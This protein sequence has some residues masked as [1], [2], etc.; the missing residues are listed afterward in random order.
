[1]VYNP[2]LAITVKVEINTALGWVDVTTRGRRVSC[3][4]QQGRT[5]NA[6]QAEPSRLSLTLGNPDGYLTEDNPVSPWYG[7]W[8]RGCEIRV[9]RIG[10]TV[11]PAERFHGQ[12][13]SITERYPGGNLDATVEVVAIGTLGVLVQGSDPLHSPL[14]RAM[15]G[16]SE[17][18]FQ[19]IE[20]WPMEA[21]AGATEFSS[22]LSGHPAAGVYGSVSAAGYSGFVGSE[23]LPVLSDGGQVSGVFPAY[24]DTG[25][26][27]V[28]FTLMIPTSGFS[29]NA[30]LVVVNMQ[31]G[32]PT[33]QI[34]LSYIH[35]S[36]ALRIACFDSSGTVLD[37]NDLTTPLPRDTPLFCAITDFVTGGTHVATLSICL[38]NGNVLVEMSA[39]PDGIG[40]GVA[41]V[42][43]TLTAYSSAVSSGWSLGH[44]ALY[45][46]PEI[47]HSP[48]ITSNARAAGGYVGETAGARMVR[49]CREEG[50]AFELTG[51]AADTTV[52]GPQLID[53]LVANLRDCE[54][55]DGGLLHDNGADGALGYRTLTD[56]YNQTASIA[57]V[58]GALEP[59][60][61]ATRDRQYVRNDIT[62][63][64]PGGGSSRV[65]DEDHVTKIRARIKD[66]RAVNVEADDQLRDDASW[67]VHLGTAPGARYTA[68]GINLRNPDGALLADSVAA[69]AIGDRFTVAT[70]ALPP[71]HTDS[72]DGLTV[73]W[74]EYLDADTWRFRAN[75]M[76]YV[77]DV[78]VYD[79]TARRY[80]SRTSALV[81]AATSSAT[82]LTVMWG[83]DDVRWVTGSTGPVF[84]I[85]AKVGGEKIR[86][87]A[88]AAS[89]SDTYTRSV[90]PTVT[91]TF[92]R[93]VSGGWGNADTG[94]TWSTSG[95]SGSDYNV[96]SNV[97]TI[98]AGVVN[99]S[100]FTALGSLSI[101]D[102]DMRAEI[103]VPVVATGA[104]ISSGLRLRAADTS[105]YYYVEADRRTDGTIRLQLV[106]R[107]AAVSTTIAGPLSKGTY[108]GGETW[109]VRGRVVGSVLQGKL[110]K[111]SDP[112][113]A[114]WDLEVVT[115]S[116]PS[117]G[118]V[119][120]RVILST[121]NTNTLPVVATWDNLSVTTISTGWGTTTSGHTWTSSGGSASESTIYDGAGMISLTTVDASRRHTIAAGYAD[122]DL[123]VTVRIPVTALTD[124][125]D[126]G[127]MSR[128]AGSGDYYL[129]TLHFHNDST[130]DVRIRKQVSGVFTTLAISPIIAPYAAGDLFTLRFATIGD[131]L[132]AMAWPAEATPPTVWQTT[133]T[134]SSMTAA[135]S[136]GV[137]ANLQAA[138]TNPLPVSPTFDSFEIT[139]PQLWTVTRSRNGVAKS[140]AAGAKVSLWSPAVYAH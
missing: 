41:G 79:G 129:G 94:Q 103:S 61:D 6:I 42:P 127:L 82:S 13:D 34:V 99:S 59:N 23:P 75:L 36:G 10:L 126:L 20:Y 58:Q 120:T 45:V 140:H 84:P 12:V 81:S 14:Y 50:T 118:P 39:F 52:M 66:T 57:V 139:G 74:T 121:G 102:V 87:D 70:T 104:S 96:A 95:G 107:V 114:G 132:M 122:T 56:L 133:T 55:A 15:A 86:A 77:H 131:R 17:G 65:A 100:R 116:L 32:L 92:S 109:T 137:R 91:D 89:A 80:D 16:I 46:D 2:N 60:L 124:S 35:A 69:H 33:R 5:P 73:G 22:A 136:V 48:N 7:S 27:Q 47:D 38:T 18:D 106:S 63:S 30:A 93:S 43:L 115:T 128:Y 108:S 97:G 88:I 125:I 90:T 4:I 68:V 21:G 26:W 54:K 3:S 98:S 138:N 112:E 24:T 67:A 29:A 28:Q 8:G 9:S 49:L 134:D 123:K 51:D 37:S 78:G 83:A 53:T 44:V 11:S 25:I 71:Q 105:N 110:W 31:P 72:I 40:A 117:A 113:P 19:P 1:M 130:V 119:G 101:A 62:S 64:R 85:D 111:T 135:G 76:P